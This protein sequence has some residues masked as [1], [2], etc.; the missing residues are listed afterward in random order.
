[1][2]AVSSSEASGVEESGNSW[3]TAGVDGDAGVVTEVTSGAGVAEVDDAADG[4]AT[5]GA[6]EGAGAAEATSE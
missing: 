2:R 6:T 4:S 5:V 1:M 3:E